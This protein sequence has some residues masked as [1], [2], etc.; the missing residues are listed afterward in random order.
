MNFIDCTLKAGGVLESSTFQLQVP[1]AIGDLVKKKATDNEVV[2][3]FRPEGVTLSDRSSP[4]AIDGEVYMYEPL[5][6][7]VITDLKV[8]EDVIKA[9]ATPDFN[10]KIGDKIWFTISEDAIHILIKRLV[11]P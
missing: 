10:L 7:E 3:G 11:K 1:V 2:L 8:G 4:G 6:S 9:R 5:G